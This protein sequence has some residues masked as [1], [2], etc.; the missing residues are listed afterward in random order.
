MK[1]L[2][3]VLL[4]G[5]VIAALSL[6]QCDFVKT[7]TSLWLFP[8]EEIDFTLGEGRTISYLFSSWIS[9]PYAIHFNTEYVNLEKAQAKKREIPYQFTLKC[10]HLKKN[11]EF[12]FFQNVYFI[13]DHNYTLDGKTYK[14]KDNLF[15]GAQSWESKKPN[16]LSSWG[17]SSSLM[18]FAFNLPYGK[19]RC[20]FKD[21]SPPN[22]K[23]YLQEAGIVRTVITIGP[24]KKFIY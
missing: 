10:Y 9:K 6:T 16:S 14:I 4:T 24:Y 5:S 13:K 11:K 12:L 22:I 3:K 23:K 15:E 19:Y 8:P 18:G 17:W 7:Q 1:T 20:D 2:N 21:E